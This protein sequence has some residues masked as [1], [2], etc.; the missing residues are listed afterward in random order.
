MMNQLFINY[1]NLSDM[2]V[3]NVD[4][5]SINKVTII[6]TSTIFVSNKAYLQQRDPNVRLSIYLESFM[7]W[8]YNTDF[9]IIIVENSGYEYNELNYEKENFKDRL[10]VISFNEKELHNEIYLSQSKGVSELN[11]INYA[12][13]ASKL[14]LTSRFVIKVTGRYYIPSFKNY[15]NELCFDKIDVLFQNTIIRCE[16][17]GCKIEH[18]R[19]IFRNVFLDKYNYDISDLSLE[20]ILFARKQKFKN[21]FILKKL[22]INK[23]LMGGN[24]EYVYFL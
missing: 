1:E 21:K 5:I 14:L 6:L 22:D 15:I 24:N 10:E 11:S 4:I 8:I 3:K 16:I 12:L 9:H 7:K 19:E 20:F 23:T 17:V 18:C 2:K 13:N